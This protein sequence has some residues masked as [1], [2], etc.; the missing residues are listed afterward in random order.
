M[1][2]GIVREI[3][4][5]EARVALTPD[6]TARLVADDHRILVETG[7]GTG[8]GFSDDAYIESGAGIVTTEQAWDTDLVLKIK[9]PQPVEYGFLQN[10]LLFTYL[11]LAGSPPDLT[12]ALLRCGTRAI[13]YETVEDADGRL[14]LLAPMSAIAGNVAANAGIYYLSGVHG[15][16]GVQPGRVLGRSNGRVMVIGQGIVGQHAAHTLSATGAE[17]TVFGRQRAHFE[18]MRHADPATL[19][20]MESSEAGIRDRI[21]S[22][23]LV[24]GAVLQTGARARRIVSDDMVRSMQPGSVIV[25]VSIDQ[26]GCV[27]TSRPTTHSDP[28][29]RCHEVIHYCVTNMPGAYART[30]TDA[31]TRETLPY[32][33]RLAAEGMSALK[34]DAGFARGLNVF[35]G[36]IT[37]KP[38]ADALGP[39]RPWRTL[40]SV[41]GCF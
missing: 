1:R 7:A 22:A 35:D 29:Y 12:D 23:D 11:H 37:C 31:L 6:G 13:A 36:F 2:I 30:A 5:R 18:S 26:G 24:I 10:N 25:D 17:V 9:E 38:V 39:D 28:V 41:T 34:R 14:P 8:C 32:V 4:D 27:E 15:G 21:R 19:H 33:R 40:D 3:K 16:R 20:F